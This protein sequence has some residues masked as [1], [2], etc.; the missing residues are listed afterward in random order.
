[1]S[2]CCISLYYYTPGLQV[3]RKYTV[4]NMLLEDMLLENL[5]KCEE[6]AQMVH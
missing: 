6:H 1:M 4:L 3:F 5:Q 2:A